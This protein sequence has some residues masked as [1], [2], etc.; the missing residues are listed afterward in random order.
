MTRIDLIPEMVD[1]YYNRSA[2]VVVD[3]WEEDYLWIWGSPWGGGVHFNDDNPI[4][5]SEK[6][7]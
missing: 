7:P 6:C 2:P 3:G 5:R 1:R 4:K